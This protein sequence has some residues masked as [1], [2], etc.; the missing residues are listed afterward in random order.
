MYHTEMVISRAPLV[1]KHAYSVYSETTKHNCIAE[2][3]WFGPETCS[4]WAVRQKSSYRWAVFLFKLFATQIPTQF[5]LTKIWCSKRLLYTKPHKQE[6]FI[7]S[8]CWSNPIC[9]SNIVI[10]RV[11]RGG[12]CDGCERTPHGPKRSAWKDPKMNLRKKRM[13]KM[14][15]FF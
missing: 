14:N 8:P 6:T 15:L 5:A 11:G 3:N 13:P 4:C 9:N 1:C 12:G 2:Y 7:T 10:R